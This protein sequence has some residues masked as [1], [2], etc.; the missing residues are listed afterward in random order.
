[1]ASADEAVQQRARRDGSTVPVLRDWFTLLSRGER[2]CALGNSDTHGRNNGSGY[3]RNYL[4]VN[5]DRPDRVTED[6]VR[7][8]IRAQRVLVANGAIVRIR[9]GG[10]V[11]LGRDD[12]ARAT[13]GMV[14]LELDVQAAP[15]VDLRTLVLFENGRPVALVS[16]GRG[17]FTTRATAG[18]G[19]WALPLGADAPG[20]SGA[21]RLRAT[22]RARVAADSYYV[23]LVRGASLAPV[24]A[25]DA[26]GYTNPTYVDVDGN[27]WQPPAR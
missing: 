13:G 22:V 6:A 5:E 17:G 7:R 19:G 24:G 4:L 25:G 12:V 2:V 16:D 26:F 10:A 18:S 15:W 8:A 11:H 21:V 27:G 9:T 3:P 14:E 23:A 1:V 20:R